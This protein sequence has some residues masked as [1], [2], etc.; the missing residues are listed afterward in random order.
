MKSKVWFIL[1]CCLPLAAV[2][3]W[4][5]SQVSAQVDASDWT[6]PLKLF[7]TTGR[8]SEPELVVDAAGV[9]HVFWAYGSPENEA[10]AALQAIYYTRQQQ[11]VAAADTAAA[12]DMH[13]AQGG[14]WSEPVDVL[15]SPDGRGARMPAVALDQQGYLH[16]AWSGGDSIYYSRAYAPEAMTP[17]AWSEPIAFTLYVAAFEPAIVAAGNHLYLLWT[18]AGNGLVL[19]RST[20]GGRRWNSPQTIF[21]APG[22]QELARWGRL[23]VDDAG[24]LHVTLSLARS[25]DG[26]R[27]GARSGAAARRDPI[28]LYYLRSEDGGDTWTDPWLITPDPNFGEATVVAW[29]ANDIHLL[30][31][32]R[33][34]THGRYHRASSDGGQTW[35]QIETV[36]PPGAPLGLGGLTGFPAVVADAQ[37]NLHLVSTGDPQNYY[38]H[39][40][41]G[42]WTQP[43]V[44]SVG[45][46]G[47]GVTGESRNMEMPSLAL[48]LGNQLHAVFHD[49]QERIWY[50]SRLL[51]DLPAVPWQPLP[52][53]TPPVVHQ[54][55]AS[56]LP[57]AT[58]TST[59]AFSLAAPPSPPSPYLALLLGLFS[60][61]ALLSLIVFIRTRIS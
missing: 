20:D 29:G 18:E 26:A 45:L 61:A 41:S 23:A 15:V 22:A 56:P 58:A 34:G 35:G 48:G 39:W 4:G 25:S 46:D 27:S 44:I 31:N 50:T 12:A 47:L 32:G 55:A 42:L 14:I 8:A 7:E 5:Y 38:T 6:P 2:C 3:C 37:G 16:L 17:Q 53:I 51:P 28:Y 21:A 54:P 52:T 33:A 57:L 43:V 59:P 24:R 19:A 40:R 11:T 30:W 9:V 60:A 49:G 13:W 1:L 10:D 36:V